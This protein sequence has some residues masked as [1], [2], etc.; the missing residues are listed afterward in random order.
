MQASLGSCHGTSAVS[1]LGKQSSRRQDSAHPSSPRIPL[2]EINIEPPTMKR[3]KLSDTASV[4]VVA[5]APTGL[6]KENQPAN[7]LPQAHIKLTGANI[8]A[9]QL[10][11]A[12]R[13]QSSEKVISL[14]ETESVK[15][16]KSNSIYD[17]LFM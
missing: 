16:L 7:T 6:D 10:K 14:P 2:S 12:S 13:I 4:N 17:D 15:E 9:S 3:I 8:G 1:M 5:V 11:E